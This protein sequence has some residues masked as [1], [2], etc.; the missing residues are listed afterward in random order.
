KA[1]FP[2]AFADLAGLGL[3]ACL[4]QPFD[5]MEQ[6]FHDLAERHP[7]APLRNLQDNGWAL[8]HQYALS[9]ELLAMSNV[10]SKD[11]ADRHVIAA[12]GAPETI[13]EL[14][15]LSSEERRAMEQAVAEMAVRGLRVLGVAEAGWGN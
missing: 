10:W 3:L 13:A 4:E 6:A 7:Q 8:R 12:K 14:C 2:A 1:P 5:P 15:G 11:S 9:P